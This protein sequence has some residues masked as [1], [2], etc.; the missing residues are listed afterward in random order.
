MQIFVRV[1]AGHWICSKWDC[2]NHKWNKSYDQV[3]DELQWL[4]ILQRHTIVGCCQAYKVINSLDCTDFHQYYRYV[5]HN[6]RCHTLALSC[7]QILIDI[8]FF[9]NT[10]Y[11][12]NS[13]P[14]DIVNIDI[15][16]S[17]FQT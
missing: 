16:T 3:L 5:S 14:S 7:V 1:H 12:W 17:F 11:V 10:P 8:L 9:V 13:L 2:V 15:I 6:S 4:T